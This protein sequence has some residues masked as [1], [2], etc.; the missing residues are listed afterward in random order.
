MQILMRNF[1]QAVRH[2]LRFY[3]DYAG[4]R[5]AEMTPMQYGCLL[6]SIGLVG[7]IMMKNAVR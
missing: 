4:D 5:W 7:W 2:Y 1:L 6:I 3:Q